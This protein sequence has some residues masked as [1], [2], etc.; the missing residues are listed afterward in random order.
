MQLHQESIGL[1]I[2]PL[3]SALMISFFSWG[4]A[5]SVTGTDKLPP[6]IQLFSPVSNDTLVVGT[7]TVQY[8]VSDDQGISYID[9]RVFTSDTDSTYRFLVQDGQNPE[10]ILQVH[11][12]YVGKTLSFNLTA[13]DQSK[14]STTSETKS[15]IHVVFTKT[16]PY[17]P[18]D[19]QVKKLNATT[20]NISWRDSSQ[21]EKGY[22]IWR[23]TGS[24]GTFVKH[25]V[26]PANT[27]NTNDSNLDPNQV[28]YYKIRSYN[29]FGFS[30]FSNEIN[31]TGSGSSGNLPAPTNLTATVLGTVRVRL[32][33][34]DNS[35]NENYFQI[36]RRREWT[37]FETVGLVASNVVTFLDSA[38]G[39]A[40]NQEYIYRVK[41][42]SDSDSAW[43][44]EI[45]VT[46]YGYDLNRPTNLTA[47]IDAQGKVV[48]TWSDN[49]NYETQTRIERKLSSDFDFTLIGTVGTDIKTYRDSTVTSGLSYSYRIR[50]TDGTIFS[51]YS[52]VVTISVPA[53]DKALL[54]N[55]NVITKKGK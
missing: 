6:V 3:L 51:E 44:S 39:L 26:M 47:S 53:P 2:L 52:E 21:Y 34:K 4:C 1:R 49:S 45:T 20:I 42:F 14:N 38:N 27:F 50:T 41:S 35:T 29:D 7:Y 37:E 54:M 32:N 13:Y 17:A 25:K 24:S 18:Y 30:A 12:S 8:A 48:L 16:P 19:V 23:K 43:S 46:T 36:E 10:I 15:N 11:A 31:S 33:W 28:Y 55:R 40:A 22:E 5:D 9:L